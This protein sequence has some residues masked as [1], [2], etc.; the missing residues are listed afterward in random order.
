MASQPTRRGPVPRPPPPGG[1]AGAG[2]KHTALRA[3]RARAGG[4]GGKK[5]GRPAR[6]C[7]NTRL[8]PP[9]PL[10]IDEDRQHV[11]RN[12][13]ALRHR[14]GGTHADLVLAGSPAEE[15]SHLL[16]RHMLEVYDR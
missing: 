7:R 5:R 4:G 1:P 6:L 2:R 3:R 13:E 14:E 15:K 12:R 11:M 16:S 10:V 8:Q 9:I